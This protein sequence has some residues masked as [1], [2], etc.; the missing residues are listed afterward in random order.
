MGDVYSRFDVVISFLALL[1]LIK[2]NYVKVVQEG[3]FNKIIMVR[4]KE[5]SE[6]REFALKNL[7]L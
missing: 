2:G 3:I 6:M 7:E 5:V 1:E 4:L